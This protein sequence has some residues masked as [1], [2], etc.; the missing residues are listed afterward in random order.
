MARCGVCGGKISRTLVPHGV[1]CEDDRKAERRGF[2]VEYEVKISYTGAIVT[3]KQI[4][5]A[6]V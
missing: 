3:G 4:G 5:R 2:D 1:I 6:H